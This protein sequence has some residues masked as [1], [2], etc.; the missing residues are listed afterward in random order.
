MPKIFAM[1]PNN[2]IRVC[3]PDIVNKYFSKYSP[4]NIA[5]TPTSAEV[6]IFE[7]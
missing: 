1:V 4:K 2:G 6:I 3:I 7:M 5:P